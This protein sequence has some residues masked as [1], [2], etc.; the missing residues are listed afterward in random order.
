MEIE[1]NNEI[2]TFT[3]YLMTN[4]YTVQ[5]ASEEIKRRYFIAQREDEYYMIEL[6]ALGTDEDGYGIY[7]IQNPTQ[8][9]RV[10]PIVPISEFNA[11]RGIEVKE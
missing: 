10:S 8:R 1:S 11:A 7:R 9:D 6:G 2:L 4:G 5:P 3:H